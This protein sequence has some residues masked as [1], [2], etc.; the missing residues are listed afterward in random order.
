[1]IAQGVMVQDVLVQ[2][3]IVHVVNGAG[4]DGTVSKY[5]L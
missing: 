5:L 1:V 4:C 3:V 2:S